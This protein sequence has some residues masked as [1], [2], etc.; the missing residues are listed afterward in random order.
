MH[1]RQERIIMVWLQW[2]SFFF[3]L[4]IR[5]NKKGCSFLLTHA[6]VQYLLRD[7]FFIQYELLSDGKLMYFCWEKK[8]ISLALG[9]EYVFLLKIYFLSF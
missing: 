1:L 9:Q 3:L 2:T 8:S 7:F 4:K 5:S 6:T